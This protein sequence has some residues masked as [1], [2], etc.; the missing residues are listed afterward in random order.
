METIRKGIFET[1]SSSCHSVIF[2]G[3]EPRDVI[4]DEVN[5]EAP[6]LKMEK[7]K[8]RMND[9]GEIRVKLQYFDKHECS[10]WDQSTKLA[11]LLVLCAHPRFDGGKE[12]FEDTV[13]SM[14][15]SIEYRDVLK[16]L[17]HHVPGLKKIIPVYKKGWGMD[18]QA[19]NTYD[20]PADFLHELS[21]AEFVLG[22][23]VGLAMGCD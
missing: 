18:H 2:E 12:D 5:P 23:N 20:S 7:L 19:S 22:E 16:S 10:E 8:L 3:Q 6:L 21:A 15:S 14:Y 1:N 9:K 11:Y 17:Q 4:Y 13:E